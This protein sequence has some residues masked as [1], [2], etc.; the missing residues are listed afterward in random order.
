M[1]LWRSGAKVLSWNG[2]GNAFLSQTSLLKTGVL[3]LGMTDFFH[4]GELIPSPKTMKGM[5]E[6]MRARALHTMVTNT[7]INANTEQEFCTAPESQ[8]CQ[9]LRGNNDKTA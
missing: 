8:F 1:V 9:A 7:W 5:N 4:V 3:K 6:P 2:S